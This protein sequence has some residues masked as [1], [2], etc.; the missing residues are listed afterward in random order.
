MNGDH[1]WSEIS[2]DIANVAKQIKSNI[3]DENLV[4]DLKDTFKT[5]INN[6]SQ[7]IANIVKTVEASV[8]DED[9]KKETREIVKN[10]NSELDSLL[11][12]TKNKFTEVLDTELLSEEE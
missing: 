11:K 7:L 6:T 8:T 3:D 2:N 12:K 10:I 4:D 1:K 5:T 9:I